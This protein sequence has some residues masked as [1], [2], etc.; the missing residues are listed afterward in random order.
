M[1][2]YI[3]PRQLFLKRYRKEDEK[4]DEKAAEVVLDEPNSHRG[5]IWLLQ[6]F[7]E[8]LHTLYTLLFLKDYCFSGLDWTFLFFYRC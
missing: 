3:I 4:E 5:K 2:R 8:F 6:S 7:D 1:G